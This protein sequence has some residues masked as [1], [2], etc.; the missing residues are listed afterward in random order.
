MAEAAVRE[1]R[2]AGT[3][4]IGLEALYQRRRVADQA[5][6]TRAARAGNLA[7]GLGVIPGVTVAGREIILVDDVI[8]SGAT[9]SEATRALRA[10][11][12]HVLAA[13]TVAATPKR[14]PPP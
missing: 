13:A 11:H 10:A 7:G 2:A 6:L 9:L 5:G 4:V 3:P 14:H 1:L 12:A 8:T